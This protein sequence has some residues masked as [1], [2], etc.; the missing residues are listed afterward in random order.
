M[1]HNLFSLLLALSKVPETS[2]AIWQPCW[3]IWA[4]TCFKALYMVTLI[5][6]TL[7]F[8]EFKNYVY[9]KCFKSLLFPLKVEYLFTS[10][11][12]LNSSKDFNLGFLTAISLY[13]NIAALF[14]LYKSWWAYILK[15]H[16][17]FTY[18]IYIISDLCTV[19]ILCL[20]LVLYNTKKYILEKINKN[21]VTLTDM[22]HKSQ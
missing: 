8:M 14:E 11:W 10:L 2:H 19:F 21:A 9:E 20:N 17:R 18:D 4:T 12:L 15:K 22:H 3:C 6:F 5:Y 16:T 13:Y 7:I 1:L